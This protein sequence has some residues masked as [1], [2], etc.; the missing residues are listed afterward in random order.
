MNDAD[1][2]VVIDAGGNI[3]VKFIGE[4]DTLLR[5][6]SQI[7][8][9]RSG[10]GANLY[11]FTVSGD[12]T[13]T[14]SSTL[15]GA[16]PSVEGSRSLNGLPNDTGY[17]AG[18]TQTQGIAIDNS[19][20]SIVIS[21]VGINDTI[22]N[23]MD[24]TITTSDG[25]PPWCTIIIAGTPFDTIDSTSA[26][27]FK[28]LGITPRPPTSGDVYVWNGENSGFMFLV[29]SATPWTTMR[30]ILF[31]GQ[32]FTEDIGCIL[33]DENGTTYSILGVDSEAVTVQ[34]QD[35]PLVA[36]SL[37]MVLGSIRVIRGTVSGNI[38]TAT[39]G[40]L[41][42]TD[43][44]KTI[45]DSNGKSS[46]I[47]SV[48]GSSAVLDKAVAQTD[49][50]FTLDPSGRNFNDVTPDSV[51]AAR[52]SI[53]PCYCRFMQAMPQGNVGAIVPGLVFSAVRGQKSLTIPACRTIRNSSSA[54]SGPSRAQT[55]HRT[56]S[57]RYS[58]SHQSLP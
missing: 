36:G 47:L 56:G 27:A 35:G 11:D 53:Y 14:I 42:A 40:A 49:T 38:L 2:G 22:I 37:A 28:T 55:R 8:Y 23:I 51:L 19:T 43:V 25:F 16:S 26:F 32:I 10:A 12:T 21:I 48:S 24:Y 30:L 44:R 54:G 50:A 45:Y 9:P 5:V 39:V 33:K 15:F 41:A 18:V 58:F 4:S 13:D 17:V 52:S 6:A 7:D 3:S 57:R 34:H 20:G 46:L 31:A 29:N 1:T